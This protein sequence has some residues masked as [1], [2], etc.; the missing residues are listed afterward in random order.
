MAQLLQRRNFQYPTKGM[1]LFLDPET[2]L[3]EP[4]C[5][6]PPPTIPEVSTR[7]YS[8]SGVRNSQLLETRHRMRSAHTRQTTLR[9]WKMRKTS[10][11]CYPA[12][13]GTWEVKKS[14]LH[15]STHDLLSRKKGSKKTYTYLLTQF[16]TQRGQ[17]RKR[18]AC[19]LHAVRAHQG[20]QKEGRKGHRREV[21]FAEYAF[22]AQF[23]AKS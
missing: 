11:K 4:H 5:R 20:E 16:Q 21:N 15:K 19:S 10:V 12:A 8:P 22:Y 9:L 13:P 2:L 3:P 17:T 23:S 18:K 1:P 6:A 14:K 7:G